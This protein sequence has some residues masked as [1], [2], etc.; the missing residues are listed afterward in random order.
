MKRLYLIKSFLL[1][2]KIQGGGGWEGLID[3]GP[4]MRQRWEGKLE[5][6]WCEYKVHCVGRGDDEQG[7]ERSEENDREVKLGRYRE[8]RRDP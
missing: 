7:V 1:K 8:V 3:H 5:N 2:E 6:F 4:I